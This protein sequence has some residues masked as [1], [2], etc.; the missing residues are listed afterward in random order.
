VNTNAT[1][2]SLTSPFTVSLPAGMTTTSKYLGTCPNATLTTIPAPATITIAAGFAIPA[3]GCTVAVNV[4]ATAGTFVSTPGTLQ[5]NTIPAP[6]VYVAGTQYFNNG[7]GTYIAPPDTSTPITLGTTQAFPLE[8]R[9]KGAPVW[10]AN[11]YLTFEGSTGSYSVGPCG[12]T[13]VCVG[14]NLPANSVHFDTVGA[15][16]FLER[17]G[18]P[19]SPTGGSGATGP[20]FGGSNGLPNIG[21]S[22]T[23]IAN[24][25]AAVVR[26]PSLGLPDPPRFDAPCG[27][28]K[29]PGTSCH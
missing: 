6:D 29:T 21:V 25:R 22:F 27:K 7:G 5:A 11:Y 15:P 4:T 23:P 1:A 2:L 8:V 28:A 19:L 3:G 16:N 14:P 20:P 12:P 10:V 26:Y 24:K 17:Q 18:T 13:D 9:L